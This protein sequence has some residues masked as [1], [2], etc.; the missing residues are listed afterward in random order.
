VPFVCILL[1]DAAVPIARLQLSFRLCH[2]FSCAFH[3]FT[4][5][6]YFPGD[7]PAVYVGKNVYELYAAH[8]L[9][10]GIFYKL[11]YLPHTYTLLSNKHT[12]ALT[13]CLYMDVRSVCL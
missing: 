8:F 13:Q 9:T 5:W 1:K 4:L 11:P 10:L 3:L 6:P 2:A 7:F 12:N